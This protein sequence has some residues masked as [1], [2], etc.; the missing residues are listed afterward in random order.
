MKRIRVLI[1]D[2]HPIVR[3]GIRSLLSQYD[4]LEVA[5]EAGTG[6]A[7]LEQV[8]R[9]QPDVVLLDIRMAGA[10]GIEIARELRRTRPE[11]RIII[12]TTYDDEEYLFGA[13]QV[14]AHAYLLKDVSLDTLP[15][16]IRAIHR[17]ER[18]LSPLLVDK[19]LREFQNLATEKLRRDAGLSEAELAIL[20]RI[21]DGATN[22]EIAQEFYWSE[23][24][25]KKKVQE[26]LDKLGAVNRTQ[27]VV[28]A[29]RKGLI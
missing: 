17:G 25:V 13:L 29:I 4:D 9:I 8:A 2:D 26:I 3:Q 21:A 27:A 1:A 28:I 15:A 12:L 19:V 22:R 24:T 11:T 14:G 18:L 6:P 5:G 10:N 16:A 7:V 23:V 20:K